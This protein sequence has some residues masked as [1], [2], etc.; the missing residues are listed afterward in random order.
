MQGEA[1]DLRTDAKR[2]HFQKSIAADQKWSAAVI[3]GGGRL[4]ARTDA[5]RRN[6]EKR[7]VPHATPALE[8]A[9]GAE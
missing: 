4:R 5:K 8:H 3:N 1:R 7:P 9:L 2:C 6:N